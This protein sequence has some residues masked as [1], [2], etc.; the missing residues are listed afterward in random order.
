M[1]IFINSFDILKSYM[2][3]LNTVLSDENKF[4][5]I[6]VY[7]IGITIQLNIVIK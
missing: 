1:Y 6:P 3:I 2:I 7:S 5:F 4:I